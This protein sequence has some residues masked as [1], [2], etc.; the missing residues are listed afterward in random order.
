MSESLNPT[1]L[2]RFI[3]SIGLFFL[4]WEWLR[5]MH[6]MIELNE[7]QFVYPVLIMSGLF[8]LMN[9][10]SVPIYLMWLIKCM[11][12]IGTLGYMFSPVFGVQWIVDIGDILVQDFIR[13]TLGDWLSISSELRMLCFLI[14]LTLMLHLVQH[15]MVQYNAIVWFVVLTLLYLA[16]LQLFLELDTVIAMFRVSAIGLAMASLLH[17]QEIKWIYNIKIRPNGWPTHWFIASFILGALIF[18]GGL[19]AAHTQS[20]PLMQPFSSERLVDSLGKIT[21]VNFSD[22][23]SNKL[24]ASKHA[25]TGYGEDDSNLGGPTTADNEIVFTA[26]TPY[27]T[28]W[29]GESKSFYN[30]T[31]WQQLTNNQNRVTYSN[32]TPSSSSLIEQEV[33]WKNNTANYQLFSGGTL[34]RIETLLSIDGQEIQTNSIYMDLS[35]G[36]TKLTSTATPISFYKLGV[37]PLQWADSASSNR[38]ANFSRNDYDQVP[39]AFMEEYLQ[40]PSQLPTR[41][42]ELSEQITAGVVT[43]SDR[44]RA[45]A[46]YLRTNYAYS[47]D[48]PTF[49]GKSEDFV[50]HFLFVDRAGYCN[51]FSSAMVVMLRSIGIPARYVKGFAP[52]EIVDRSENGKLTVTVRNRDAHS[53]VEVY[54]STQ[55][56]ISYEPTPGFTLQQGN[57]SQEVANRVIAEQGTHNEVM[58]IRANSFGDQVPNMYELNQVMKASSEFVYMIGGV[59]LL[60]IFWL[61]L[62]WRRSIKRRKVE[63][64]P[65]SISYRFYQA[66][67]QHRLI[68]N[69]M[70]RMW[71]QLFRKYGRKIPNQTA[72]EYVLSLTTTGDTARKALDEFVSLY[73]GIRHDQTSNTISTQELTN[74]WR[75]INSE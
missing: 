49:P 14:C 47:L 60:I 45:I 74:L 17:L 8:L 36:E 61:L 33:M 32:D 35:S 20:K 46:N 42:R 38:T 75:R 48:K 71:R 72:R 59:L 13:L 68:L 16:L 43:D 30:G 28:Y 10:I 24:A 56:W 23:S 57:K 29:R 22:W 55:G 19:Y 4:I 11:V 37:Q 66:P 18:V 9:C 39:N 70:D 73:E 40:L 21:G 3:L 54:D 27:L 1:V 12:L 62:I 5:P 34:R 63:V 53:W 41:I 51:H 52:G 50:D 64:D 69:S 25:T 7:Q 65:L 31:G 15:V 67:S 6:D 2:S 58:P 44:A 26:R